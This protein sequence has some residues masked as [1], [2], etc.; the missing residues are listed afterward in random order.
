[1]IQEIKFVKVYPVVS[2][3]SEGVVK[4]DFKLIFREND[5]VVC[6][7]VDKQGKFSSMNYDD[8]RKQLE[9]E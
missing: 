5:I 2:L 3:K 4:D 7:Y 6:G 9:G 1:M 8:F